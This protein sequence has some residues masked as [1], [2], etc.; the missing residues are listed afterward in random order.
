MAS[1]GYPA[2]NNSKKMQHG[3]VMAL[4]IVIL[5]AVLV[6]ALGWIF[7][8]SSSM[9]SVDSKTIEEQAPVAREPKTEE[10]T[11][12]QP[13]SQSV[14]LTIDGKRFVINVNDAKY[15]DIVT[16]LR[17]EEGGRGVYSIYS[18][19]LLARLN[20]SNGRVAQDTKGCN[21]T[22]EVFTMPQSDYDAGQYGHF[23]FIGTVNSRA[24]HA[25]LAGPCDPSNNVNLSNE[26]FAF[27][28]YIV[29]KVKKAIN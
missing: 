18:K 28:D 2:M 5:A 14:N 19:D 22:V 15:K 3:D 9:T 21:S 6:I 20:K 16:S 25:G 27:A 7:W 23:N 10:S 26:M 13:S 11:T 12:T 8:Q 1:K 4:T 24:V 29:A 17:T